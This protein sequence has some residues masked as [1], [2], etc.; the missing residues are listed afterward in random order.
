MKSS[1]S[2]LVHNSYN[3]DKL[4]FIQFLKCSASILLFLGEGGWGSRGNV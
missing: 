1:C 4:Y 2:A 3:E